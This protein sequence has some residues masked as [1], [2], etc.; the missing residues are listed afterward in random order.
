MAGKGRKLWTRE[1]LSSADLQDYLQ[2]QV[3]ARFPNAAARQA[4]IAAPTE[5]MLSTLDD[6]D[7]VERYDGTAWLDIQRRPTYRIY[8]TGS[9]V[10]NSPGAFLPIPYDAIDQAHTWNPDDAFF[11]PYNPA[12]GSTDRRLLVKR[13]G[14]YLVQVESVG[15]GAI[16]G[17]RVALMTGPLVLG[18][19]LITNNGS[20]ASGVVRLPAN[21]YIGGAVLQAAS[22]SPDG[23][24]GYRNHLVV[25]RLS[26]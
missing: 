1:T 20:N 3:V 8:R 19:G 15:T 17:V 11:A 16:S 22:D 9:A 18:A 26:S 5:G 14:L 25:T 6:T 2:D 21:S 10:Y 23:T 4:Q 12:T 24:N 13:A 7:T